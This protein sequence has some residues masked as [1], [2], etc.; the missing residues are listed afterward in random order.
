MPPEQ[1]GG[2]VMRRLFF[3]H[4]GAFWAKSAAKSGW[5]RKGDFPLRFHL[6][7]LYLRVTEGG[8]PLKSV[9]RL[10]ADAA[11]TVATAAVPVLIAL[12]VVRA[13]VP[14]RVEV[15]APKRR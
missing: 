11:D 1:T 6:I 8:P 14:I 4:S 10:F 15:T 13:P 3:G 9:R 7:T 2:K 5:S 12:G